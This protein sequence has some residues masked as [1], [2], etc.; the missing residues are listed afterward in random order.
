MSLRRY[1]VQLSV[2]CL[3]GTA[4][5]FANP[6]EFEN[7]EERGSYSESRSEDRPSAGVASV[8]QQTVELDAEMRATKRAYRQVLADARLAAQAVTLRQRMRGLDEELR[9]LYEGQSSFLVASASH[10]AGEGVGL[11]DGSTAQ[12]RHDTLPTSRV[13][14]R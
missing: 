8:Q 4:A 6:V 10:E 2:L 13:A 9:L 3:F 7:L 12:R 5:T 11:S 14:A 1:L